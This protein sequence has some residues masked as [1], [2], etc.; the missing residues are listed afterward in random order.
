M[1]DTLA[2]LLIS[3]VIFRALGAFGVSRFTDWRTALA[4]GLAFMMAVTGIAHFMPDTIDIMPSHDDLVTLVPGYVPA[5]DF[6]V[7]A[8]GVLE[9]LGSVGLIVGATRA[10][11]GV[12]LIG[13]YIAMFPANLHSALNDVM[14]NGD[15]AVP[16]WF[17]IPEQIVFIA[18]AMTA[19][20]SRP[21]RWARNSA[22]FRISGDSSGRSICRREPRTP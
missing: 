22:W 12:S 4:H 21:Y 2:L 19:I 16:L 14:L 7:Y 13:L 20:T 9:L 1:F 3:S 10:I 11:A 15:P 8:T 17:R 6:M 18:A 5:P